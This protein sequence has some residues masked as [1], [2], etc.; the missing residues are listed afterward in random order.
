M[1]VFCE[2]DNMTFVDDFAHH[3]TAI[4]E[5]ICAARQRWPKARIVAAFEPRTNTTR[6]ARFQD[7]LSEA[8]KG[9]DV[10]WI[11]PIARRE[12][13]AEG[14]A[15]DR[16]ALA[17][18][19]ESSDTKAHCADNATDIVHG[20]NAYVNSETVVLLLSNGAFDGIYDMVRHQF[21][22]DA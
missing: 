15:L 14:E 8:L 9:A 10:V 6:T 20:M 3:P 5:T 19:L 17:K 22:S 12:Q 18:S 13:L 11:G 7:E 4:R 21:G 2:T 1:E 16:E